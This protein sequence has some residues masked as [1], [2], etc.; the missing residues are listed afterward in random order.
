MKAY[1]ES[2]NIAPLILKTDASC[3]WLSSSRSRFA[4]QK[5]PP[6]PE[7]TSV[8]RNYLRA[9]KL[10]LYPLTGKLSGPYSQSG[11]FEAVCVGVLVIR[12]LLFPAFFIVCTVFFVLFRLCIFI[13][14]CFVCI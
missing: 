3:R 14:I 10:P 11:R 5:L 12:L 8:P 6:Y 1:R 9:Q 4:T 7:I 2:R 13:L